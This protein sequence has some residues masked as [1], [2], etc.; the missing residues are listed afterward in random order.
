MTNLYDH[1]LRLI[2]RSRLYAALWIA[3]VVL[4]MSAVAVYK[5]DYR[6]PLMMGFLLLAC[7]L[8]VHRHYNGKHYK[9]LQLLSAP[10]PPQWSAFLQ[11]RSTYYQDLSDE[12]KEVFNRR[13]QFFI[14]EKRIHAIDTT[15]DDGVRLMVGASAVI[16][17]FAFP[18]FEYP[19]VEEVLI[20]PNS[21]DHQFQTSRY[22]GHEQYITGMVGNRHLNNTVVLSKP[23]LVAGFNGE[24]NRHNVGIHEF[25]HLIDM[26]DGGNSDGIPEILLDRA[27][28]LP[29]LNVIREEMH[30]M[31]NGQSDI[32]PYGLTNNA[33]FLAVVSEYFFDNPQKFLEHHPE[34]YKYLSMI[35]RQ[36]KAKRV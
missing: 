3:L 8:F 7:I 2:R 33:E 30:R 25:V 14:K 16:P 4:L 21:F 22:D 32:N 29:W 23:D 12:E 35:F 15:I 18:Y 28:V 5:Q 36:D 11:G 27:Y 17:T 13:V 26:A 31:Q 9:R 19:N 10:F 24:R 20:Y 34:L 1:Y 6:W